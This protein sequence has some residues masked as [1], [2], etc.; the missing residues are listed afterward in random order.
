MKKN[1]D[2]FPIFSCRNSRIYFQ[3]I[4]LGEYLKYGKNV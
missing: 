2:I 1:K 3:K 4:F